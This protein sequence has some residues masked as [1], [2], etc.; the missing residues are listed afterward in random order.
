MARD[1]KEVDQQAVAR[2][3]QEMDGDG[4]EYLAALGPK[5]VGTPITAA[6]L[7]EMFRLDNASDSDALSA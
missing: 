7:D 4:I 5:V 1:F 6:D 3:A 2:L